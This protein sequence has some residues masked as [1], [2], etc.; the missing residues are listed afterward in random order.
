MP[1]LVITGAKIHGVRGDAIAVRDGR[2]VG[3]G[4]ESYVTSVVPARTERLHLPG[5]MVVP[6]FQDAHV[7][8]PF[9]GRDQ[10]RVYLN[11]L[12]GKDAYLAAISAYAAANPDEEWITGGGW[13]MEHFPGGTPSKQDLDRI[14]PDRPVF[15]FNRDV[16][17]AWVNSAAL[18]IGG[19][20]AE[21][22]DPSDGRIERDASGEPSGMLQEGAAYTFRDRFLPPLSSQ[23]WE[24]AILH[25]QEY[26]HRL[27]ITGWQDAW[28]TPETLAAY[29]SL[30]DS[31]QLTARVAA[32]L[33]WER[34]LGLEQ[35]ESFVEQASWG[36]GGNVCV[37][38]VKIMTDGVLENYTGALLS[39]YHHG[40]GDNTGLS[41]LNSAQLAAAV[42]ELDRLGFGVHMHAIGD[43]ACRDSLD[44][45]AAARSTNGVSPNRHHIAHLQLIDPTDIP[46][47][48]QLGVTANMQAY[49][50]Q[51]DGQ[52][53]ELTRPFLGDER[54]NRMYPFA[55]LR[56]SGARIAAGSDWPVSTPD[57]LAQMEVAVRRRSPDDREN[58]PFLP[59]QALSLS[60]A[61][62]AFT[63]GSAYVNYDDDA[64][65]IAVGKR[66]DLT[67]LDQDIF[68]CPDGM[69]ADATVDFT[70]VS[71][72]VVYSRT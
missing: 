11:D 37:R 56:T 72:A 22:P 38:T 43:R 66:A 28:V 20:T 35:V 47:F 26:L 70:I 50:A 2:I 34:H 12:A 61:L 1:D 46:R 7:H 19:I 60:D 3:V 54:T 25:A 31:G 24:A 29:R 45:V 18:R 42:T 21:T 14:V 55:D 58:D 27:G 51:R 49:W 16:H 23:E 44:A 62:D 32:A 6:G 33:W 71:G 59:G 5:K 40:C 57:P 8:A 9:A 17:G 10:L 30:A 48:G 4:D 52:L 15:L 64:G 39:P 36:S 68:A 69:V 67:I 13:A 65:I 63:A 53:E 41:Y